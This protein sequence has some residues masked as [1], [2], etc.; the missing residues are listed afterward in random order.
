MGITIIPPFL[1]PVTLP[2]RAQCEIPDETG[3]PCKRAATRVIV[4]HGK[5][6][7]YQV[8]VCENCGDY[9]KTESKNNGGRDR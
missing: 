9:A 2:F 6:W 3:K 8:M 4:I 7:T 1:K 5:R